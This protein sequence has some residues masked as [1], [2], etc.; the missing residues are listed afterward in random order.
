MNN[1]EIVNL[2]NDLLTKACDAEQGYQHAAGKCENHS[3]IRY[4][5]ETQSEL[6]MGF[7]KDIVDMI[8]RF[9]GEPDRGACFTAKAH[10]A[11]ISLRAL[12]G[13]QDSIL[14]ECRR[15]EQAATEVYDRFL[16]QNNL[17]A[18]VKTLLK[19]QRARICDSLTKIELQLSIS[20]VPVAC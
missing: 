19:N 9:G 11:W 17:P 12:V 8:S 16:S 10:Q 6:R 20:G 2:L 18:M 15:G 1:N 3:G 13:D 4:F 14:V 5:L 7:V